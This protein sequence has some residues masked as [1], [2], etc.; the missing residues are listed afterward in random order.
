MTRD[1]R[2]RAAPPATAP[3]QAGPI[4]AAA[5]AAAPLRAALELRRLLDPRPAAAALADPLE[6][7]VNVPADEIAARVHELPPTGRCV[8]VADV[9]PAAEQAQAQLARLGRTS[10][11]A[12][13]RRA[14]IARRPVARAPHLNGAVGRLWSPAALL[15]SIAA[16]LA[17]PPGGRALDV[18]CGAGRDAVFLASLGWRVR[19]VDLLPDALSRAADLARRCGSAITP[20]EWTRADVER[21]APTWPAAFELVTVFRFLHRPLFR[22]IADWLVPGGRLVCETFTTLHRDR[23]GKPAR[24][25]HVLAPGEL[26]GL[27]AAYEIQHYSE[28]WCGDVHTARV[29]ARRPNPSRAR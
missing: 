7:A 8:T 28:A 15:E 27:L 29:V 6:D 25:A 23:H 3:E 22:A 14:P 4:R 16:D 17:P 18:A 1:E 11:R 20:I 12:P 21:A 26:P 19:G 9:G 2:P 24:D 5:A 10:A 13:A